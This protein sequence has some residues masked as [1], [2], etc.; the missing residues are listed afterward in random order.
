MLP[1]ELI[2]LASF[3]FYFIVIEPRAWG[4]KVAAKVDFFLS[5]FL[6]LELGVGDS[7]STVF[8]LSNEGFLLADPFL[9]DNLALLG[10]KALVSIFRTDESV[11]SELRGLRSRF[12]GFAPES[13]RSKYFLSI[14]D[15]PTA[16]L[17][18]ARF[19]PYLIGAKSKPELGFASDCGL[20]LGLGGWTPL[21]E[22]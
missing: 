21:E 12:L 20:L 5:N 17:E 2:T 3:S 7:H 6:G 10:V 18:F 9:F 19:N 8:C 16:A 14:S 22:T 15:S 1:L 13:G 4:S 11:G